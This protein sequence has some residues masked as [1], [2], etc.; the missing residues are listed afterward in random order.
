MQ[1]IKVMIE[2]EV[3]AAATKEDIDQWVDVE[4]GECNSMKPDN[5]CATGYSVLN[6]EWEEA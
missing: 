5:P 4:Y 6:A 1:T 3:P 2:I